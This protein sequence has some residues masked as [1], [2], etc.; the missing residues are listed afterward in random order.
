M[1]RVVAVNFEDENTLGQAFFNPSF[2]SFFLRWEGLRT[3]DNYCTSPSALTFGTKR[4]LLEIL[5]PFNYNHE[6]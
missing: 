2:G 3:V 4:I 1:R 5:L 6:V